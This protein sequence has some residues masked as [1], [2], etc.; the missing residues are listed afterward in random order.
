MGTVFHSLFD[1]GKLR[2]EQGLPKPLRQAI[3]DASP[4]AE[5]V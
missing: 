5:L 2:L 1:V 3:E 4:I